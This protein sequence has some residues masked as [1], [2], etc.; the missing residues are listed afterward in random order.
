MNLFFLKC[1]RHIIQWDYT[2]YSPLVSSG[3]NCRICGFT[4]STEKKE[5]NFQTI[6]WHFQLSILFLNGEI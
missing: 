4:H 6:S 1:S 2:I 5:N 3:T